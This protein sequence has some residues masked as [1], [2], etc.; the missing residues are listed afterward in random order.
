MSS[1]RKKRIDM[2]LHICSKFFKKCDTQNLETIQSFYDR[3]SAIINEHKDHVFAYFCK[4]NYLD[5]AK[6]YHTTQ[7][8]PLEGY[9]YPCKINFAKAFLIVCEKGYL[10]MAQWLNGFSY[11]LNSQT[12]DYAFIKACENKH[13]NI[14][15]WLILLKPECYSV[16]LEENEQNEITGFIPKIAGPTEEMHEW[17][18]LPCS[19]CDE[20]SEIITFCKH[21]FCEKCIHSWLK[22]QQTC[23]MCRDPTLVGSYFTIVLK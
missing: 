4:N 15:E 6:W 3:H 8:D 7:Y 9:S 19:I 21:Q 11:S 2:S 10:E 17:E 1:S 20:K 22:T 16:I 14:I 12:R 18:I 5:I 13:F 23:P